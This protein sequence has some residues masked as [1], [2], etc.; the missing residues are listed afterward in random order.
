MATKPTLHPS[1]TAQLKKRLNRLR[2]ADQLP[3]VAVVGFGNELNGDDAAGIVFARALATR[4]A[5]QTRLLVIDAG[6][7]PENQTGPLRDFGPDLVLFVDAAHM[8]EEPGTV[9]LLDWQDTTGLSASTHTLPPYVIAKYLTA[10][11]G[12]EVALLGIQPFSNQINTL[13][14]PL[15][16]QIVNA[17]VQTLIG[18][19]TDSQ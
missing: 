11:I 14:S 16:Q 15:M 17:T 7:A 2:Q 12:C 3:R 4:L 18:V 9:R 1:W 10:E 6:I 5:G 8:A 19:L 13:V